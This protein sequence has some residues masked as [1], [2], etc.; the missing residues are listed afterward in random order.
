M[1]VPV[2]GEPDVATR[3]GEGPPAADLVSGRGRRRRRRPSSPYLPGLLG[4]GLVA[5][6]CNLVLELTPMTV[7]GPQ[8]WQARPA[9][10]VGLFVLG[11]LVLWMAVGLLHAVTGRLSLTVALSA[12]VTAAMAYADYNKLSVRRE[13]IYPVDMRFTGDI[14]F[15][16]DMVGL[17]TVVLL[18][19]SF[20][21]AAVLGFL[22]ARAV[23]RRFPTRHL[24]DRGSRRRRLTVRVATAVACLLGLTYVSHFN[25]PHNLARAAYDAV[26]AHW[27]PYDQERNYLSNGFVGGFLYNADIP[28][29]PAPAGY[30]KAEMDRIVARYQA[31]ADRIN[32]TRDPRGLS[33]V[34]VVT[35]LS[36]SFS[37]PEALAG[38]HVGRDP[39]PFTRRLM[40]HTTSGWMRAQDIGG[41]TA[42]MEFEALTGMSL[43]LLPPQME[44]PYQDLVP[45]YRSFPSVVR[46][47]EGEGHSAVAIHPYTTQM[48]RRSEVYRTFGFER[49]IHDTTMHETH[50]IGHNGYISDASAFHEVERTLRRERKPVFVNLVTMQNH[51]PY[52]GRYDAPLAV[53]GPD[54]KPLPDLGQYARGLTYTDRALHQLIDRLRSSPEKTVVVFYGDHLPGSYP[55]SVFAANGDETMHQTPFFVWANFPGPTSPQPTTSPAHFMDLALQRANAAV[56]PYY[57]LLQEL[58]ETVPTMEDGTLLDPRGHRLDAHRLPAR[59]ARLLHDYRMVEYDLSVGHR[60]SERGLFPTGG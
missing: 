60:Y 37:D 56:P 49:F 27:R 41:G 47:L 36:E 42:N 40:R 31:A 22:A 14:G 12:C 28:P 7:L 16:M 3:S 39:I 55:D 52:A 23:S 50:R 34:N 59:T 11:C 25:A 43:S 15:L 1:R 54:G 20:L 9:A 18:T 26:G 24:R 8:V 35:I 30:G 53:R 2:A 21:A 57:A 38:V 13:P 29:R 5:V 45:R 46:W 6:V 58:R 44:V 17:R 4:T 51:M 10:Y 48:Y 19:V 33:H 32:R